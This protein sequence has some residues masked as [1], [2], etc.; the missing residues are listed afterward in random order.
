MGHRTRKP[1]GR[2]FADTALAGKSLPGSSRYGVAVTALAVSLLAAAPSHAQQTAAAEATPAASGGGNATA[3]RSST[4]T[5]RSGDTSTFIDSLI[6]GFQFDATVD[7]SETYAT[8][9]RGFANNAQSDWITN[10][11]G[12]LDMH[13]HSRRVSFDAS[14]RGMAN[15]YANGTQA[16]QFYNDLQ[17]LANVAAIPDYVNIIGRAFAQPVVI[18]NLGII[19]ANNAPVANGYRDSWGYSIGPELTFHLGNFANSDT[20]ATYSAS[21]FTNPAGTTNI[22]PIPGLRGPQDT[23][24][25]NVTEQLTSGT[26]FSRLGW[27]ALGVWSEIDRPQSLLSEKTGLGT[28]RYAI[29]REFALLGTGGYDAISNTIPLT[30]NVTGPVAMGGVELTYAEDFSLQVQVGQKYRSLSYQG[31]LRWNIGATTMITGAATDYITTPE[32]QLLNNL[33][34]LSAGLDGT[35]AANADIYGNGTASSL[36]GFSA[37]P[38]GSSSFNQ[39][40]SRYQDISLT[41]AEDFERDHA[42][43][44]LHQTKQTI[45]DSTF[46]GQPSVN[47]WGGLANYSHNITRL[48]TG[49]LGASYT[50]Y[51]ELGGNARI[52]G[53][54]GGVTYTLSEQTRVYFRTDYLRRNSSQVV[55]SISPF[56]GDLD[57]TRVTIGLSHTL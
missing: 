1:L 18:S 44:T 37:Q 25:R 33:S 10:A 5:S 19:T 28:V 3:P 12:M 23:N 16:T 31:S 51:Q 29:S 56:T 46:L 17:A 4:S 43:V 39:N 36:A 38:L 52:L 34:N 48:L 6:P 57:D 27:S 47:S 49:N 54:N 41:F 22:S 45:L 42:N 53:F 9:A 14:Y 32:G 13:D 11:G 40:I 50:N 20:T 8:N 24:V 2:P 7:V 55:Q 30:R 26:D 15:V 21:Y 35:L